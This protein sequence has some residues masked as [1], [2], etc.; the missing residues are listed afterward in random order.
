MRGSRVAL[1]MLLCAAV[2]A[3]ASEARHAHWEYTGKA[4]PTHWGE[5]EKDFGACSAGHEQ[6]PINLTRMKDVE[7]PAIA[8]DYHP[9]GYRVVNNGHAV[10]VDFK[11]GSSITLEGTRYELK[12]LHFHTPSENTIEGKSFP[13]EAH[14]VHADAKGHLAVVAVM[15]ESGA[16]NAWLAQLSS[17][18]PGKPETESA[19]AASIAATG[20][21]PAT[22][23]YYGF[24]GSLT[25]PP[26]S[27]GVR[28]LVLKQTDRASQ[29]QIA[30]VHSAIGHDNSRPVQPLGARTVLQ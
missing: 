7:L 10:Q 22:R 2:P 12:Q 14:L 4:G 6:S 29:K 26:C 15:F 9:G 16:D 25:T 19:L 3:A 5:L 8:F 13:M 1:S 21:L 18:V 30:L 27:E 24:N 20:L 23:D 11:P 17:K 28:W